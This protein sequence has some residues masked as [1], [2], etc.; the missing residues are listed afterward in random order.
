VKIKLPIKN[1]ILTAVILTVISAAIC[2]A[3]AAMVVNEM[4]PEKNA[5]IAS[6]IG[7]LLAVFIVC[8]RFAHKTAKNRMQISII[9]GLLFT[10]IC[11]LAGS[12]LFSRW[13]LKL[14]LWPVFVISAS[15]LAGV[16]SSMKKERR[17]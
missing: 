10:G 13:E 7:V 15:M 12:A 11:L 5:L 2:M 14:D 17:R 4:L 6:K 1:V 8:W 9:T 16:I 3:M